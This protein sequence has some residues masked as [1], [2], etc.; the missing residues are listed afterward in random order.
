MEIGTDTLT[1]NK[2]ANY[3]L[4]FRKLNQHSKKVDDP[5]SFYC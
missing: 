2:V 1:R 4:D 3:V 5:E